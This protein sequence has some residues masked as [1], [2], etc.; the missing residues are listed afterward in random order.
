MLLVLYELPPPSSD[1]SNPLSGPGLGPEIDWSN[2]LSDW[3]NPLSGPGLGPGPERELDQSELVLQE[4]A[5][6]CPILILFW[7]MLKR[8]RDPS[9]ER[10]ETECEFFE[11][12]M[13]S[14]G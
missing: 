1:W 7:D 13:V 5:L 8:D 14:G 12:G 2:P 4:R 3:S 11:I 9:D 6:I 10:R